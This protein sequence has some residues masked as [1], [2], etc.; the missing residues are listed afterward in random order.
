MSQ[1]ENKINLLDLDRDGLKAFIAEKI[2][3]NF[4][5]LVK[6]NWHSGFYG[7]YYYKYNDVQNSLSGSYLKFKF[8]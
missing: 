5:F 8:Y 3:L 4:S 1:E 2:S 6:Q 7:K